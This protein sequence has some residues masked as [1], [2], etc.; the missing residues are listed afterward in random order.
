MRPLAARDL[1]Q[2]WEQAEGQ[3]PIDKALT[4]LTVACSERTWEELAALSIGQRDALLLSLRELTFGPRLDGFAE[5]PQCREHLE[6][7]VNIADLCT[8]EAMESKEL[9][10]TL[11]V[12]GFEVRF[13]LPNSLDLAAVA[14]CDDVT[15][16]RDLLVRRCVLQTRQGETEVTVETL[17]E[18]VIAALAA[19]MTACDP[20]SEV[21]LDLHCPECGHLWLMIL[22][23][24]SF[25]WTEI[26]AQAKRLLHEVHTLA[27]AYGWRE[28]DILAMSARRRQLYLEMVT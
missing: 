18:T 4:L 21:Q 12:E 23:I 16:A 8:A 22:D 28:A 3:H 20:L 24:V 26:A 9:E 19:Y 2:V 11:T 17:P 27:R 5:C 10:P 25:F 1:L 7:T 14:H 6:C 13:R 15:V